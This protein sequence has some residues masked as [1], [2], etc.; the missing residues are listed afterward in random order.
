MSLG[1]DTGIFETCEARASRDSLHPRAQRCRRLLRSRCAEVVAIIH[2]W[3][4]RT[5]VMG[6]TRCGTLVVLCP[7]LH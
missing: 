5:M 6:I 2:F 4:G 3:G 1:C 7:G